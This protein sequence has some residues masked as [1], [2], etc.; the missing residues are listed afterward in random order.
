[1]SS[2][3]G[4]VEIQEFEGHEISSSFWHP[5]SKFGVAEIR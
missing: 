2:S 5:F 1:M 4:V 3:E